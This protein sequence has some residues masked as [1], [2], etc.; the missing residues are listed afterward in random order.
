MANQTPVKPAKSEIDNAQSLWD[1]F[2]IWSKRGI[3]A[4]S[5]ILIAMALAF[6]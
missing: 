2:V 1:N 4:V 3:I 6:T 5:V